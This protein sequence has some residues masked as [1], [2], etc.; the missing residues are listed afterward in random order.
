MLVLVRVVLSRLAQ[1]KQVLHYQEL[2]E[3]FL[4][5]QVLCH[6]LVK[7]LQALN[8]IS[9]LVTLIWRLKQELQQHPQN[10]CA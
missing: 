5:A 3:V 8:A 1:H 10:V 2:L 9:M 4:L 6:L 7:T